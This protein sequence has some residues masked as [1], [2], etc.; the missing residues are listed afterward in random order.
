MKDY[1]VATDNL[2]LLSIEEQT[3]KKDSLDRLSG[4][5]IKSILKQKQNADLTPTRV[6]RFYNAESS[7]IILEER[8]VIDSERD[9]I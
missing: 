4:S 8:N 9:T 1:F 5:Q 6:G 2:I 3:E 7:S